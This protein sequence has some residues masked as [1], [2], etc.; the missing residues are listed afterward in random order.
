MILNER[1]KNKGE[2][3]Y[4]Q[5][6]KILSEWII[7]TLILLLTAYFVPGFKIDS[8]TSAFA[9]AFVLAVLNM[10]VKPILLLLTLPATIL[11]L[12]L[13]LFVINA[14]LLIIAS[15]LVPGFEI[16]SFFTAIVASIVIT[17]I[18]SLVNF[19]FK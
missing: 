17:I 19:I 6:M 3:V 16:D 12:G 1:L 15:K 11:S 13:F 5:F 10:L 9:V 8:Y 7:R 2:I 18:S 4:N 14:I